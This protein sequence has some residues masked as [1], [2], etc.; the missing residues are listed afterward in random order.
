MAHHFD[1]SNLHFHVVFAEGLIQEQVSNLTEVG[2]AIIAVPGEKQKY[3]YLLWIFVLA[4][5]E[6]NVGGAYREIAIFNVVYNRSSRPKGLNCET[7]EVRS[8]GVQ[9][10]DG[11]KRTLEPRGANH[12]FSKTIAYRAKFKGKILVH[13]SERGIQAVGVSNSACATRS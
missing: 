10:L 9:P 11:G 2:F 1:E 8:R 3:S 4:Q 13:L 6:K 7:L 5:T 12:E